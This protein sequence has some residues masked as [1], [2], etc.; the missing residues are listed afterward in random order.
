MSE[1]NALYRVPFSLEHATVRVCRQHGVY[2]TSHTSNM[3]C[4]S[5]TRA[6]RTAHGQAA[7]HGTV[8]RLDNIVCDDDKTDTSH[9]TFSHLL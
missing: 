6:R 2:I 5:D 1:V 9:V 4:V 3:S 7:A 8:V